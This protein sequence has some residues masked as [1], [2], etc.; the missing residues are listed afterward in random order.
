MTAMEATQE[1]S[2]VVLRVNSGGLDYD[3]GKALALPLLSI[4]N[5]KQAEIAK[6]HGRRPVPLSF[7]YALR[8]GMTF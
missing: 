1:L 2:H 7:G 5:A 3:T 6:R 8:T 4:I